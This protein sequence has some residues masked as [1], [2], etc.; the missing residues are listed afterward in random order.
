MACGCG[1]ILNDP[2]DAA[3]DAEALAAALREHR[4]AVLRKTEQ[5]LVPSSSGRG[6]G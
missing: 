5:A 1:A 4:D 6:L 2:V 3:A